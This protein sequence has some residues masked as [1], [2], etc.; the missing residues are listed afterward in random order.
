MSWT[1]LAEFAA[2]FD[3]PPGE[4][5]AWVLPEAR[6]VPLESL[7]LR[8][9][10]EDVLDTVTALQR[11]EWLQD[12]VYVGPSVL[13]AVYRDALA[14]ARRM[15]VAVPPV[16]VCG[17]S[18]RAQGATG[19]DGRAFV[20]LSSLWIEGATD[21]ERAFVLGRACGEIAARQV[22]ADSLYAVLVDGD[23]L[24]AIARRAVGPL[25]EVALAPIGLAARVAL[26]RWHRAAEMSADRA[27]LLVCGSVEAAASSLLRASLS[28]RPGFGVD[29]WLAQLRAASRDAAPGRWA[30]LLQAEPWAHKRIAALDI[31]ARSERYHRLQGTTG[32]DL[33]SDADL[34]KRTAALLAVG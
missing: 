7:G 24:R 6:E 8:G 21:G 9:R 16:I 33:V 19:T 3:A 32:T 26:S 2:R 1:S 12:G 14:A 29:A 13:P 20:A 27:G 4:R 5:P 11:A 22:T 15:A 30:E 10:V 34:D 25:L 28:T 23:G 31:F 17:V 18:A